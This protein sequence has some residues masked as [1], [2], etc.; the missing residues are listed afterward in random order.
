MNFKKFTDLALLEFYGEIINE[1]RDRKIIRSSNNP[2]AD[3][4]EYIV[5]KKLKLSLTSNS[6]KDFDAVDKKTGVK[7]QIKSRRITKFSKS[8]Q[9]GVIRNLDRSEFNFLIA[10]IFDEKF[11]VLEIY[12]IPKKIIKKY[13]RFSKHQNGYILQAKGKVLLDKNVIKIK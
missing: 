1:L 2:V 5:A 13:A 7:Y 9:L 4:A 3:Y 6:N 12:K 10:V 11:R 8:R